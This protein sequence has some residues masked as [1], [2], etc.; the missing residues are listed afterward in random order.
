[1]KIAITGANGFIGSQLVHFLKDTNTEII[2]L[3]RKGS[4]IKLIEKEKNISYVAYDNLIDLERIMID[5]DV[6][7]HCAALTRAKN[8][9]H[10][11]KININLTEKLV[12]IA[13]NSESLKQFIFLSSQAASGPAI[14]AKP[15]TEDDICNPV[16][17]YGKSKLLAEQ[18]IKKKCTRPYTIIRPASVYGMGDK[19]FLEYF[20]LIQ[21]RISIKTGN[22]KKFISLI[23]AEDLAWLIKLSILNNKAYNQTFFAT[24][25]KIYTWDNFIRTLTKIM[26]RKVL[27]LH[28]PEKVVSTA[29]IIAEVGSYMKK[30]P[31]LL[32]TEK[33]QE[34]KQNFWLADNQ[35]AMK[36]LGFSAQNTLDEGLSKTYNWYLEN[37]WL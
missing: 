27:H 26:N 18:E 14:S 13:N 25:G 33:V 5:V 22:Q 1:M 2:S 4:D 3:V 36:L 17:M 12:D 28:I 29:A 37:K 32:N 31:P 15:K 23:Y 16:S 24:D 35:K 30:R 7:I 9:Y 34:M 21:K 20:K 10:F 11:K 8:W 6:L 19:D